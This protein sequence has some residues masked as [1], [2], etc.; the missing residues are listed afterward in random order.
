MQQAS[1]AG[2]VILAFA[3]T[4]M[5]YARLQ[6]KAFL[7]LI[8]GRGNPTAHISKIIY[9]GAIQNFIFNAMQNALFAMLFDD[10][11][12]DE[13]P[14]SKKIRIANGM[15]DSQ[16]RGLGIGGAAAATVKNIIVNLYEQSLKKNP[17]YE[18]ASLELLSFSPPID[19]K[20]TKFRSALRS[21]SWDS[22]EIKAKGFSLDNPGLLAGAQILSATTNIPLDRLIKKYNNLRN[23]G[24][25]DVETWQ[26]IALL[27]GWSAWELGYKE[28]KFNALK[29]KKSIFKKK[30]KKKSIFNK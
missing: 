24:R 30:T 15:A 18:D 3:N 9:Y 29:K 4:P 8:N 19:S 5:Q 23:A 22:K 21:F 13:I 7:D 6:K 26:Q 11:D 1:T 17:K 2:R 28:P 10:E 12:E 25:K 14:R 27:S 20:V 16:L